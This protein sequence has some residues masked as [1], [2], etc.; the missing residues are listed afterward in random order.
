MNPF[1]VLP[2]DTQF[3]FRV[4]VESLTKL[5][6]CLLLTAI[7]ILGDLKPKLGGGKPRCLGSAQVIL[8]QARFWTPQNA[9]TNYE[10]SIITLSAM[11]LCQQVAESISLIQQAALN[12]LRQILMYP[13]DK[14]CPPE[15]Y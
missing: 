14:E 6:M 12:R 10:R 8:Q 5:E 15:L 7:G 3:D 4:G 1:E 9:V 11:Q 13:R 2:K